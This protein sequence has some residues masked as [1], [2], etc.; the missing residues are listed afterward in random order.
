MARLGSHEGGTFHPKVYLFTTG[1]TF[2]C[3]I[4]SSNM[5]RGGFEEN[6]EM[7]VLVVGSIDEDFYLAVASRIEGMHAKGDDFTDEY[8]DRY[9]AAF[10]R[11]AEV[12]RQL[13]AAEAIE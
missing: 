12:R 3:I 10:E 9:R 6:A 8:I 13:H 2:A 7:N 11:T 5:T 1:R 4:G